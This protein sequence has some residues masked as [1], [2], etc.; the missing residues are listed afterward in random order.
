[1]AQSRHTPRHTRDVIF[2]LNIIEE[3]LD[4]NCSLIYNLGEVSKKV[5]FLLCLEASEILYGFE[6]LRKNRDRWF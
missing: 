3:F 1:M 5:C 4:T 2:F 6:Y